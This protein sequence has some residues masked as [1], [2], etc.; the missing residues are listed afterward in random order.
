MIARRRR[1]WQARPLSRGNKTAA[2][3]LEARLRSAGIA[4]R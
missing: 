3:A 1:R 4:V 2:M